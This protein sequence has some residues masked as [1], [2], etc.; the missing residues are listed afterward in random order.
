MSSV[1]SAVRHAD[2]AAATSSTPSAAW[3]GAKSFV[4]NATGSSAASSRSVRSTSSA[5]PVSER[6]GQSS[7]AAVGSGIGLGLK[8]KRRNTLGSMAKSQSQGGIATTAQQSG[9]GV[10]SGVELSGFGA[11]VSHPSASTA[12]SRAN[13]NASSANSTTGTPALSSAGTSA[14]AQQAQPPQPS[15]PTALPTASSSTATTTPHRSSAAEHGKSQSPQSVKYCDANFDY[16]VRPGDMFNNRYMLEKVIGR[17]S[18]GQVVRAYDTRTKTHVA[19]KIIKNNALYVEQA[20]SEVRMTA[21]LNRIDPDDAH[22]IMR[23]FDKFIFRGH[24][25]LVLELLSFSL[26]DLLRSTEFYG[27]SLNLVRKFSRQILNCLAFLARDD[28]NIAHCDLKPENVLL[29]HPQRSAIKV[30]DFGASCRVSDSMFTYVQSRFYRAPE[31]IL[32]LP[33][34]TQV[35]VWSL[36][37]MLVELHTGYPLFAG[38]DEADQIAVIVERLGMPPKHMLDRGKKTLLFFDRVPI[39][40][41]KTNLNAIG[42][43]SVGDSASRTGSNGIFPASPDS[44]G[45]SATAGNGDGEAEIVETVRDATDSRPSVSNFSGSGGDDFDGYEWVL[46]PGLGKNEGETIPGSQPIQAF[47]DDLTSASTGKRKRVSGGH[48]ESDY[49]VFLDLASEMLRFDP[50]DRITAISSL[51]N[52]FV[53]GSSLG[54][55]NG[56]SG[57]ES[58]P[59]MPAPTLSGGVTFSSELETGRAAPVQSRAAGNGVALSAAGNIG[60]VGDSLNTLKDVGGSLRM[61]KSE[62]AI[63]PVPVPML[64]LHS[65]DWAEEV[66]IEPPPWRSGGPAA[67][68][69]PQRRGGG[70]HI[71]GDIF[72]RPSGSKAEL[73]PSAGGGAPLRLTPRLA[74]LR[75]VASFALGPSDSS[76]SVSRVVSRL[77]I[78]PSEK[79]KPPIAS[80]GH[81]MLLRRVNCT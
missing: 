55:S 17:G 60:S 75:G 36:G 11:R 48:S 8:K 15:T 39:T 22:A 6:D 58:P 56:R 23:I 53:T 42:G 67:F 16:I 71:E 1:S 47:V 29:R 43:G 41:R 66:G 33:Y 38:R 45:T 70:E 50:D 63:P 35:D 26:Y 61:S 64:V 4:R 68:G 32:G 76:G 73:L 31:V 80:S 7:S 27:V 44:A 72:H 74:G 25:C 81:S 78:F 54:G 21:Y 5:S 65:S 24:Q 69:K 20:L 51:A 30:V 79:D 10:G 18:F 13:S 62:S 46:K 49:Q 3:A 9:G 2:R 12:T 40:G 52:S 57:R 34:S 77:P 19:I 59:P 28:V 37:C 14:G